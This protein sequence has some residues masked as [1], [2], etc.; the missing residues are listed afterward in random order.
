MGTEKQQTLMGSKAVE[1]SM[2]YSG[3]GRI[4]FVLFERVQQDSCLGE[5]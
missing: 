4:H 5:P 2:G 3:L 1:A